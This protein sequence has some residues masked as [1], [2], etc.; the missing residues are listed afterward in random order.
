VGERQ[1]DGSLRIEVDMWATAQRFKRGHR[2]RLV[3]A[4][5]QHPR[6][7]RNLNTGEPAATSTRMAAAEQAIYHDAAHP[8]ALVVPVVSE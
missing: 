4:S 5:A 2:L 3:V 8:S 1:A 6:W 7:A